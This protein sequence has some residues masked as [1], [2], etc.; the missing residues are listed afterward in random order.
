MAPADWPGSDRGRREQKRYGRRRLR[1]LSPASPTGRPEPLQVGAAP[2]AAGR[3]GQGREEEALGPRA[4]SGSAC[5]GSRL[6]PCVVGTL[7]FPRPDWEGPQ[8]WGEGLA[9][10]RGHRP[11]G[12]LSQGRAA[13]RW[14]RQLCPSSPSR[15]SERRSPEHT[16]RCALTLTS[17]SETG[18]GKPRNVRF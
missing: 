16:Q 17:K 1:S 7:G 8:R 9:G 13:P 6:C 11:G 12:L 4:G 18:S 15:R 10:R 14:G 5:H 2:P 3:W